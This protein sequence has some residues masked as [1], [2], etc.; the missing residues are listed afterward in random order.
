ML[1]KAVFPPL[2]LQAGLLM[3]AA[4]MEARYAWFMPADHVALHDEGWAELPFIILGMAGF[5][6]FM[7]LYWLV[8]AGARGLRMPAPR[9][10]LIAAL[11]LALPAIALYFI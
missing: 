10:F 8:L 6:I 1:S 11:V 4:V 7:P 5:M 3:V 9:L 2:A